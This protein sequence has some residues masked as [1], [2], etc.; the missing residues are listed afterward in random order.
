M[1]W[2]CILVHPHPVIG[3]QVGVSFEEK[4]GWPSLYDVAVSL[5]R[6]KTPI[7]CIPNPYWMYTKCL[8]ALRCYGWACFTP[9]TWGNTQY[10]TVKLKPWGVWRWQ[11]TR[12]ANAP[13]CW[14]WISWPTSSS[15]IN[16]R[17]RTITLRYASRAQH[18]IPLQN[19]Q[20]I[21]T[22]TV[23]G[24]RGRL[25]GREPSMQSSIAMLFCIPHLWR[26]KTPV[27]LN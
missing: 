14:S 26:M 2:M 3:V 13:R 16:W 8:N 21:I 4:W 18:L 23:V 1:P 12:V 15:C 27:W 10:M 24:N 22:D 25:L 17:G 6:L 5:L 11:Y 19:S 20:G 9:N 7:Y